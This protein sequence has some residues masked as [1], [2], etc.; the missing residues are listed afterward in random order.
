MRSPTGVPEPCASRKESSP[1]STPR[2][3]Q[4]LGHNVGLAVDTRSGVAGLAGAIVVDGRAL[5]D[6]VNLV[7]RGLGVR[8]AF[9]HDHAGAATEHR[10]ARRRVERAH[11]S[12]GRD[13]A[14]AVVEI[15]RTV[16]H[17]HRDRAG[18]RDIGFLA[19]QTLPCEVQR[20]QRRRARGLHRHARPPQRELVGDARGE[21]ILVV[22]DQR[23]DVVFRE[24]A[25][26]AIVQQVSVQR[27][28]REHPDA[29]GKTRGVAARVL[30]RGVR[31]LEQQALLRIEERGLAGRVTEKFRVEARRIVEH[32]RRLHI[33]RTGERLPR[34]AG[35]EHLVVRQPRD[36]FHAAGEIAPEFSGVPRAGKTS[37]KADDRDIE[38]GVHRLTMPFAR[39]P[40]RAAL[41]DRL[42]RSA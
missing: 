13:H 27:R 21:E 14:T 30:E 31:E 12:V 24:A 18:Q 28:A 20:D 8:E 15:S 23:G 3:G 39:A 1:A 5:D 29:P 22:A 26:E 35:R 32:R 37:R 16:R 10:A 34:H 7:A 42:C 4:R 36:R 17:A 33:I 11:V 38:F 6:G 40:V 2:V 41:C 9:Q 25:A 19:Q